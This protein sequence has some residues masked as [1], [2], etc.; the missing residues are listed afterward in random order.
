M[1]KRIIESLASFSKEDSAQVDPLMTA[2]MEETNL[3]EKQI[4][5]K[6]EYYLW[7]HKRWKHRNEPVPEGAT[8]V[9]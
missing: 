7:T 8:R 1:K 4:R 9:S 3:S 2:I 5:E 6:P